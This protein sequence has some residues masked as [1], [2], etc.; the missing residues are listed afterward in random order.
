MCPLRGSISKIAMLLCV[1]TVRQHSS[2]AILLMDPCGIWL[3]KPNVFCKVFSTFHKRSNVSPMRVHQQ[4]SNA[5]VCDHCRATQQHCDFADGPSQDMACET[6]CDLQSL[7]KLFA[8][9]AM[10]PPRGSII[11]IAMLLCVTTVRQHCSIAILL[12]DP[13]GIWLMKPNVFCKVFSTFHK[14]ST[15]VRVHQQ[16]S[17]AAVCDHCQATHQHCYF[18]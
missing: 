7:F 16:N 17:N 11:K 10:C 6:K 13:R 15:P 8:P 1:T 3:M 12:M 9:V 4:N 14:C 5:T 2:I 18:C